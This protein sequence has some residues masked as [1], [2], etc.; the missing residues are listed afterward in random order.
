MLT[1]RKFNLCLSLQHC[2]NGDE[3]SPTF[4][5]LLI[6]NLNLILN[7]LLFVLLAVTLVLY[8]YFQLVVEGVP[9]DS[10]KGLGFDATCSLVVLDKSGA[11]LTISPDG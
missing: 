9:A 10:V 7:W 4:I 11:P 5:N 3:L 6:N 2:S 1:I 8:K